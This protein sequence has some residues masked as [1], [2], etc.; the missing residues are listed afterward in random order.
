[1]APTVSSILVPLFL[2]REY[3]FFLWNGENGGYGRY[4]GR[5]DQYLSKK[6]K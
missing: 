6:G 3:L 4:G 2:L 5:R 1:V